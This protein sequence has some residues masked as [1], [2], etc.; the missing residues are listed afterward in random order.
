MSP[1]TGT[2]LMGYDDAGNLAWSAAGLAAGTACSADG[3]TAAILARKVSRGYDALD[4]LTQ[5]VAPGMFGTA[6][7]TY[8]VLD[9][10]TQVKVAGGNQVRDHAYCYDTAWRLATIRTGSCTGTTVMSLGYD[11][12]GNLANRNG[13]AYTFDH[14]NRLRQVAGRENQYLYDGHGRRVASNRLVNGSSVCRSIYGLDGKL[15]FVQDQGEAKRKEYIYLGASLIAERSLPNTGVATPVSIRYQHTD[16]LGS[17]VAISNESQAVVERTA[18][19]PYGWAVNRAERNGPGYTGHHEDAATGLVYMEQR[20]YDPLIGRFLSVDPVTAY[21]NPIG[22]FNRYWYAN[23][24][25]YRF[26]DP[27]GRISYEAKLKDQVVPVHIDDSLPMK[28]QKQLQRQVNAG[29]GKINGAKLTASEIKVVQNIKSLDVS[30][31]A[32]RSSVNESKGALTLTADYVKGSS[33]SWLGSAIAHD[34]K[35]VD[36]YKEGGISNSRGLDAEAKAMTFQRDVG[37]KMGLSKSE[38]GYLNNLISN[39]MLLKSYIYS[40]PGK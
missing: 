35:H 6:T 10:L 18:Y 17:P 24:N 1:E 38:L 7:Y 15:L 16:A 28:Q 20:Y 14:G 2:T 22:A 12:H 11:V 26:T 27:D 39:P 33:S 21:S 29:L 19:E 5:V 37:E 8:D 30:S 40:E 4:R 31:T 36:L 32:N 9:N 3:T 23:D 25:P 34:G 13:V